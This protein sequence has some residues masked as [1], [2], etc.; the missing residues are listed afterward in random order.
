[1][2]TLEL[3]ICVS[4]L[5]FARGYV[6]RSTLCSP[7]SSAASFAFSSPPLYK[8]PED[9]V[10]YRAHYCHRTSP[11]HTH[12]TQHTKGLWHTTYTF[13]EIR[14]QHFYKPCLF[15]FL[16]D[17][18]QAGKWSKL[19]EIARK[20]PGKSSR[21]FACSKSPFVALERLLGR[22]IHGRDCVCLKTLQVRDNCFRSLKKA[23]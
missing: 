8:I 5:V 16:G 1:M 3:C 22:L 17:R 11:K 23:M 4:Q 9:G 6:G 7:C 13:G 14:D 12:K 19:C 10:Q 2:Y 15:L 21:I 18:D 20:E